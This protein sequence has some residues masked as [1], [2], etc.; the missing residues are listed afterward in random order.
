MKKV[1]SL[2]LCLCL[3]LC[4]CATEDTTETTAEETSISDVYMPTVESLICKNIF[5]G[6]VKFVLFTKSFFAEKTR[7]IKCYLNTYSL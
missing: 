7:Q 6:E 4:G 2:F 5:C 3:F 1:V